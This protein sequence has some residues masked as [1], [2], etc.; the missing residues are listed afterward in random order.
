M[1]V[2]KLSELAF[3]ENVS[4]AGPGFI[5]IK[6][7]DDF[8]IN[9]D[10]YTTGYCE[11]KKQLQIDMDYGS[12]NIGK[13]LHIGHLRTTVVGDTFNRIARHLG[14][15]TKSYNHM[16]DWGRPMG[17]II[18]WILENGMP[19]NADDI[20]AMYPASTVRAKE[21]E[22]W[23]KHALQVTV[24]L[25]K[26]NP[27]YN[28]IY[29]EFAP[30]SLAQIDDILVRLNILPFDEN[31]GEKLVAAYVPHVQKIL[32][33]KLKFYKKDSEK[34]PLSQL[35]VAF[36]LIE[37]G[38]NMDGNAKLHEFISTEPDLIISKG[39]KK[40]LDERSVEKF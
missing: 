10:K 39:V 20:N 3:V 21:D 13:A 17:L 29:N 11:D 4:V 14:H 2:P 19:K 25:Q 9:T 27:E 5:N 8:L 38:K 26:G 23:L 18:A 31:K 30:M 36:I 32:D 33:E 24:D 12:Y 28:K 1:I 35:V 15:K 16:G 34:N 7:K 37:S 6:L 22:A 40:Y